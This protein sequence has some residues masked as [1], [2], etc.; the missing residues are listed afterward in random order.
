MPRIRLWR[1]IIT[2]TMELFHLAH[3]G[4]PR[5][6]PAKRCSPVFLREY[7]SFSLTDTTTVDQIKKGKTHPRESERFA[8]AVLLVLNQLGPLPEL[9][10]WLVLSLLSYLSSKD[11]TNY[12]STGH[13]YRQYFGLTTIWTKTKTTCERGKSCK[14]QLQKWG[15]GDGDGGGGGGEGEATSLVQPKLLSGTVD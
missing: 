13:T 5:N 2:F 11:P 6:F 7:H 15:T 10:S 14:K 3:L 9:R 1:L 8:G 12:F 4:C